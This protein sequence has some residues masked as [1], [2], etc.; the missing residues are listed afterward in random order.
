MPEEH[1][2]EIDPKEY[3]LETP[4]YMLDR[5]LARLAVRDFDAKEYGFITWNAQAAK[6]ENRLAH[7]ETFAE[8]VYT[9]LQFARTDFTSEWLLVGGS[10]V[11]VLRMVCDFSLDEKQT[12]LGDPRKIGKLKNV[13]VYFSNKMPGNEFCAGCRLRYARGLLRDLP[14]HINDNPPAHPPG[15]LPAHVPVADAR[16]PYPRQALQ[17]V[18]DALQ[19]ATDAVAVDR[20]VISYKVK[21]S[22][23]ERIA[24]MP[25]MVLALVMF[26]TLLTWLL[27]AWAAH[28]A[29]K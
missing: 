6:D 22:I 7:F 26:V 18:A 9:A 19:G 27:F 15:G 10:G 3:A 12:G 23:R 14:Y 11:I 29:T 5:L 21:P 13:D 20:A 4:G 25:D 17:G 2:S 8:A 28:L 16:P 1:D 24:A